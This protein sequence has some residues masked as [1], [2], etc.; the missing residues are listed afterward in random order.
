MPQFRLDAC[1][2]WEPAR[3]RGVMRMP[4][5]PLRVIAGS[6]AIRASEAA[7]GPVMQVAAGGRHTCAVT[8]MG[9]VKCWDDNTHGQL[10]DGTTTFQTAPVSVSGLTSGVSSVASGLYH[11]CAARTTGGVMCWGRNVCGH[12]GDRAHVDKADSLWHRATRG[13]VGMRLM[14]GAVRPSEDDVTTVPDAGYRVVR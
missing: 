1:E 5:V 7:A 12:I 14:N 9:G 6:L 2:A 10:G 8:D 11:S 3:K 13:E 4:I